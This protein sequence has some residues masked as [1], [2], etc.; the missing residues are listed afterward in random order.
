MLTEHIYNN[1]TR[2]FIFLLTLVSIFSFILFLNI[3]TPLVGDDFTYMY[4]FSTTDKVETLP[5]IIQSQYNHYKNWGGRV[6]VHGIAQALLLLPSLPADIINSLAFVALILLIYFL[7]N[8]KKPL[9]ISLLLGIFLLIWFLEPFAETVLWITG[10]AN[11]MWGTIL[12]LAFLLIYSTYRNQ[13][14]N[15]FAAIG[16]FIFGIIAGW[17]NENTGAGLIVMIMLFLLYYKKQQWNVP[18]W[19]YTGLIGVLIGY[20]VMIAAPGNAVRASASNSEIS[21][22]ILTY[23]FFKYSITFITTLGLLN[24]AFS[25]LFY[26]IYKQKKE[27]YRQI[28]FKSLIFEIG[29]FIAVYSMLLSPSFPDRAWFGVITYNIIAVGILLINADLLIIR[30]IKYGCIISG[31]LFFISSCYK[32]IPDVIRTER[33]HLERN[34]KIEENKGTGKT[35]YFTPYQNATKYS[36]SDP[37]YAIPMISIL[38]GVKVEYK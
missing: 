32:A 6:I 20:T 17:T 25:I 14:N 21:L 12:V 4:I 36:L 7:I 30:N 23:R 22:F 11:Y 33:I 19:A 13:N 31:L 2:I 16:I 3:R 1:K 34:K 15:I 18:V 35:I 8:H 27:N 9:S 38:Y 29:T 24:V 5:D 37:Y 26:I 10:S 28:L